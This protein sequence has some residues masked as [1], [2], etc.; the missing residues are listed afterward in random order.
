MRRVFAEMPQTMAKVRSALRSADLTFA[1]VWGISANTRRT[2]SLA[3]G[4][5]LGYLPVDDAEAFAA[6]LAAVEPDPTDG[7]VGG[8]FT[9]PGFGIDEVSSRS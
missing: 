6:E 1:I 4:Y 5:E 7:L 2:W 9:S 8:G 3:A